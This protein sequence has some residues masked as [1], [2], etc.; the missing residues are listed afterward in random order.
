MMNGLGKGLVWGVVA[1]FVLSGCANMSARQRSIW[2]GATM[3]AIIGTGTGGVIGNH[4]DDRSDRDKGALIG[5][6]AGGIIGGLAGAMRVPEEQPVVAEPAPEPAPEPAQ[7]VA[8]PA[9]EA[10]PKTYQAVVTPPPAPEPT[11]VPPTYEP[12]ITKIKE[13]IVLRGINFLFDR[14][15]IR[16]EFAPVLDEAARILQRRDDVRRVLIEGH[17]CS[18]GTEKYNQGLSERRAKSVRDALVERGVSAA[19]LTTVGYGETRP[20]ADNNSWK[21]RRMNRRVEFKVLSD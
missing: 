8:K 4:D 11:P 19:R 7:A 1:L 5:M 14:S 15:D 13:R 16:P 6:L 21:G 18:I 17:T 10:K 12:P 3:G 20:M 9:P 2:E